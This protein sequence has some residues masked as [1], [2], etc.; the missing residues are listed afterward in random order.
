MKHDT[1]TD[2]LAVTIFGNSATVLVVIEYWG[3]C[4]VD[5]KL[6]ISVGILQPNEVARGRTSREWSKDLVCIMT[7]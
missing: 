5:Q 2:R 3:C 1:V 7:V 6:M 4:V